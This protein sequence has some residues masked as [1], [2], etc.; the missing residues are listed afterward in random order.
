MGQLASLISFSQIH[1]TGERLLQVGSSRLCPVILC[2]RCCPP[3]IALWEGHAEVSGQS[4]I[5][6]NGVC[7]IATCI[8]MGEAL[9]TLVHSLGVPS[10]CSVHQ[11]FK[12]EKPL[13]KARQLWNQAL[14][15]LLMRHL[16]SLWPATVEVL[17][18]VSGVLVHATTNSFRLTKSV[19]Q[20]SAHHIHYRAELAAGA[21]SP[22]T[23]AAT[24]CGLRVVHQTADGRTGWRRRR[25]C[26]WHLQ[27]RQSTGTM[28]KPG[29][30][31]ETMGQDMK[32]FDQPRSTSGHHVA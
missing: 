31:G 8:S 25:W 27:C 32:P 16:A 4:L 13:A 2:T 21:S 15:L 20:Y 11:P 18:P 30:T 29:R 23:H 1:C 3:H 14:Q 12:V 24:D 7:W 19:L 28:S 5:V 22:S 6:D 10:V 17:G 9:Q 26:P